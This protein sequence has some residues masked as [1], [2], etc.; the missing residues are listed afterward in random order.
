[1]VDYKVNGLDVF[2]EKFKNFSDN[3]IIV[4]GNSMFS[5]YGGCGNRF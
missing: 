4:G 5:C 2:A 1:M 3:F